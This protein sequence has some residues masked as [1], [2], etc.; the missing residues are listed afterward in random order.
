MV[1]LQVTGAEKPVGY[2]G[3]GKDCGSP[4]N[5]SLRFAVESTGT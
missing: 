4:G 3:R 5:E 2:P 1:P